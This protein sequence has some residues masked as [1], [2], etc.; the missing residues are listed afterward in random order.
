MSAELKSGGDN[1]ESRANSI[2]HSDVLSLAL[3]T[4]QTQEALITGL[5]GGG[6]VVGIAYICPATATD[7]DFNINFLSESTD[8]SNRVE[9]G[10]K[11]SVT[12][13]TGGETVAYVDVTSANI[14][15]GNDSNQ[16]QVEFANNQSITVQILLYVK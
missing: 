1:R 9:I 2:G 11:D 7:T 3:A 14:Y 16:V 8:G 12:C 4:A 15:L 10:N 13:S 5:A 6:Q